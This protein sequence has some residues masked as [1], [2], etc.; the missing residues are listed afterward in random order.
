M[1]ASNYL[2]ETTLKAVFCKE[3]F[4]QISQVYLGLFTSNPTPANVGTEVDGAGYGRVPVTF[5]EPYHDGGKMVVANAD[6]I[7]FSP[8]GA[9]WGSISHIGYFT[10]DTGGNMLVFSPLNIVKDFDTNDQ[11]KFPEGYLTV[12]IE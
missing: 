11:V 8:C 5:G 7:L 6:D 12:T 1:N 2:R 4:P 3:G 10:A 9:P